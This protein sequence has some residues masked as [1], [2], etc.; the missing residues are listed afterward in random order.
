MNVIR[1]LLL[2]NFKPGTTPQQ[3]QTMKEKVD[4][5]C[6]SV[7]SLHSWEGGLALRLPGTTAIP[8]DFGL[9]LN[10]ATPEDFASYIY[11]PRH[12]AFVAEHMAPLRESMTS[13]QFE[14]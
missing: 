9:I 11:D 5:F 2:F 12:A 14:G 13:V 6:A 3:R 4:A 7:P 8:A 1:H 10:F